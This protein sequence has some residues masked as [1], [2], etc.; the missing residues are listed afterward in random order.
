M[1]SSSAFQCHRMLITARFCSCT[2]HNIKLEV[3]DLNSCPHNSH[4]WVQ[5]PLRALH[6]DEEARWHKGVVACALWVASLPHH[7]A[8][9]GLQKEL[10][11]LLALCPHLF[12][13]LAVLDLSCC[14][15]GLVP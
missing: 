9:V 1:A 14:T 10:H 12:F 5:L 8:R 11:P 2:R 7:K 4:L 6:F 15:C 3:R 13:Y